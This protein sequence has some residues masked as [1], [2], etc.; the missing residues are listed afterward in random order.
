[1]TLA[2]ISGADQPT[3]GLHTLPQI[4][5]ME[6]MVCP[7]KPNQLLGNRASLS[8]PPRLARPPMQAE[9]PAV[10]RPIPRATHSTAA[11]G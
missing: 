9:W 11:V 8:I 3:D 1:M 10:K 2:W 7:R 6:S 5:R 4:L